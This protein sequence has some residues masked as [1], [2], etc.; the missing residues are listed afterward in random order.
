MSRLHRWDV[1]AVVL[2]AILIVGL[3]FA[4]RPQDT[5]ARAADPS[6]VH[7]D[8][9]QSAGQAS[10][11]ALFIGD[12]YT[13][14]SGSAEMSYPCMAAVQTGWLCHLS[15]TPGTGFVSGG[16]ANRFVLNQYFG[17]S[18]SFIERIPH[19]AAQFAPDVVVFDGGRNDQL[20][21]VEEVYLAMVATLQEAAETWP[22]ATII[23]IRPRFLERPDDDL[24]YDD[25]F[26]DRLAEQ[27]PRAV[28]IDPIGTLSDT[29]TSTLLKSDGIHPNRR[30]DQAITSA[31]VQSLSAH[32]LANP[33]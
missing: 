1:A 23:V 25:A 14:G 18:K 11:S 33:A 2:V 22:A 32:R 24:G 10:V 26:F 5:P 17:P 8:R 21:P 28:V 19:L 12:S 30:G 31:L 7:V 4:M 29:D 13:L 20:A 3:G 6:T 27:V 9:P 15:A 16:T